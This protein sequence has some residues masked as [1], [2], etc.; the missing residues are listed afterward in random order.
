MSEADLAPG[1]PVEGPS[2]APLLGP[3]EPAPFAAENLEGRSRILLVCEHGG[4]RFPARLGPLE[5]APEHREAHFV[6]DIG[7]LAL[8]RHLSGALDAPLLHQRYSR[9]LCDPNRRPDVPSYIPETGEGLPVPGNQGLSE[10]ERRQRTDEIWR[11]FHDGVTGVLDR[12]CAEGRTQA[13]VTIHSFTPAFHGVAR[14]WEAGVLYD[15]DPALSPALF[16]VLHD[17]F[18]DLIGRNEPYAVG[19]E[20]DYTIPVHGEQRGLPCVEIEVRN[21]L[22]RDD[23]GTLRWS[24]ILEGALR[25]AC[26]RVGIEV[27]P[28][29]ADG[30]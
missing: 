29:A 22:L 9:L 24:G 17:R 8:A 16:E 11:P 21:D 30:R 19:P 15:R 14:P 4:R 23:A 6:W 10:A 12:R 25:E 18:G 28:D 5:L 27:D 2:P 7:A 1:E 3:D 20:T 26:A 13:L